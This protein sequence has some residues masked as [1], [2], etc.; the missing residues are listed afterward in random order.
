MYGEPRRCVV[1]LDSGAPWGL[2]LPPFDRCMMFHV[3]TEGRCWVD[4]EG[5]DPCLIESGNVALVPRGQGHRLMGQAGVRPV[6]LFEA[7]RELLSERYELLR[8]GGGGP[9]TSMLCGLVRFD[10]PATTD[11][12]RILPPV[13]CMDVQSSPHAEWLQSTL[14][15]V[16]A[17]AQT[18]SAGSEA[19]LTRLADILVV[20]TIRSWLTREHGHQP[21]WL[22]ALRDKRIGHA[23]SLI[24]RDATRDWTVASL[25]TATGMSRSTL[26]PASPSS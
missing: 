2:A 25:A 21:G 22:G 18:L 6:P 10:H 14:R 13:I 24:Q 3:V 16:A 8:H 1:R 20:E 19:I 15:L 5:S 9:P 23:L 26:Q 4:L 17:E 7:P 12:I 11:L